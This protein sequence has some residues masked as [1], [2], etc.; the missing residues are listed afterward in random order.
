MTAIQRKRTEENPI[1]HLSPED[2]EEIGRRLDE[3]R[4]E[5]LP[6]AAPRTRRTSAG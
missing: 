6:A 4:D 2:I 1:A 3:I 5:V